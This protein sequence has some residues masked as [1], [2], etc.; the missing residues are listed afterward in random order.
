MQ[1]I[2]FTL[3]PYFYVFMSPCL[4]LDFDLNFEKGFKINVESL[5]SP[6]T[7]AHSNNPADIVIA[8]LGANMSPWIDVS[9]QNGRTSLPYACIEVCILPGPRLDSRTSKYVYPRKY[10]ARKK[11]DRHVACI[12][13]GW[14]NA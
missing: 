3:S 14:P 2:G 11:I 7:P 6:S 4:D 10:Q 13:K 5:L 1:N 8:L 9:P 12:H